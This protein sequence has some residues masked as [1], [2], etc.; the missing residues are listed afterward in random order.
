MIILGLGA[1]NRVGKFVNEQ[2]K[3]EQANIG[4][5]SVFPIATLAKIIFAQVLLTI[6][7]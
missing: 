5:S 4:S 7:S 3:S 2:A 1:I 6:L